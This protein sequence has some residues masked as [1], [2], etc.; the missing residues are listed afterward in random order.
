[1]TKNMYGIQNNS[2]GVVRIYVTHKPKVR[3]DLLTIMQI[4][5]NFELESYSKLC[6]FH[7]WPIVPGIIEIPKFNCEDLEEIV[8]G[9][10]GL[11]TQVVTYI[12]TTPTPLFLLFIP[13]KFLVRMTIKC[14]I[15]KESEKEEDTT[16]GPQKKRLSFFDLSIKKI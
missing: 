10:Q 1:M 12:R 6:S 7:N 3:I 11:I 13:Y 9:G 4:V 14:R 8:A 16:K 5:N 15:T 2:N